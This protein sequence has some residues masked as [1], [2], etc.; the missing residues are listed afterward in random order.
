MG[1]TASGVRGVTLET[2]KDEVV[3]MVCVD[4]A[5]EN[6]SILVLSENGFGKRSD[7]GDYRV[8]GRGGKGVKTIQITEKTG[9]LIGMLDVTDEDGLMIINRNGIS[10]RLA[11]D[12][13]RVVGRAT[14]G[15][16]LINM[17]NK[18]VIAAMAKVPRDEEEDEETETGEGNPENGTDIEVTD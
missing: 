5:S 4:P 9:D 14:Q 15:V 8:T 6:T 12:T 17:K 1:R 18:D 11:I 2:E 16:K 10:I 7:L 3:G 13:L